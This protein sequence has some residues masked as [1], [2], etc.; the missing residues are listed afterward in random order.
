MGIKPNKNFLNIDIPKN[1]HKIL[2]YSFTRKSSARLNQEISR[3]RPKN[4]EKILL[5]SFNRNSSAPLDQ[6]IPRHRPRTLLDVMLSY[7]SY[8]YKTCAL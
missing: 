8:S 7:S 6:E 4:E 3:D 2:L 5:Y 1:E